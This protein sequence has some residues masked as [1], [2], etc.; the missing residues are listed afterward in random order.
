MPDPAIIQQAND[1]WPG[2]SANG[3]SQSLTRTL[4]LPSSVTAGNSIVVFGITYNL[5]QTTHTIVMT[6]NQGN[7]WPAAAKKVDDTTENLTWCVFCL[8]RLGSSGSGYTVTATFSLLEYQGLLVM[9]VSNLDASPVLD[10]NG[11]VQ[12]SSGTGGTLTDQVST[13]L[14]GGANK[15][16][17]YS[18]CCNNSDGGP[19]NGTDVGAPNIGT[20]WSAINSGI[21]DWNGE[22]NTHVGPSTACEVKIFSSSMG[23]VTPTFSPKL[24]GERYLTMGI[25]LKAASSNSQLLLLEGSDEL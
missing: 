23:T 1:R 21:V 16:V 24:A 7:T 6:D 10:A 20:G 5:G 8:P 13:S 2:Q 12:V 22:E 14:A 4:T 11:Q 18:T 25:A 19:I 9:E 15:G 3:D 17:V